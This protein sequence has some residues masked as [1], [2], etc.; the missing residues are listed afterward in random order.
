MLP[1]GT[2]KDDLCNDLL[3]LMDKDFS[4]MNEYQKPSMSVR[5]RQA[6]TMMEEESTK[7][8]S[9]HELRLLWKSDNP[10]LPNNR[11]SALKRLN[12]LKLRFTR[13]SE[14]Y[15]K[16]CSKINEY[17]ESGYASIVLENDISPLGLTWYF[18]HHCTGNKFRVV[19][20]CGAKFGNTSINDKLLQGL[21]N[22]LRN[23]SRSKQQFNRSFA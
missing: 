6:L 12:G 21:N 16:Y 3:E 8:G 23:N 9:H 7:I 17:I 10:E 19:F 22:N 2:T 11:K 5:D 18:P 15:N 14:L 1:V 4:D 13:D 20:D